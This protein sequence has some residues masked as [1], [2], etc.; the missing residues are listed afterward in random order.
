M[1]TKKQYNNN[2]MVWYYEYNR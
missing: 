2:A 1:A